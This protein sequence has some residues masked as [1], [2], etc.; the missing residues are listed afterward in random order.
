MHDVANL[1]GVASMTV[2][3]VINGTATVSEEARA[4]VLDAIV[5]LRYRPNDVARSLRQ[6]KSR[7]IGVIVPNIEDPF[8]AVCAQAV[9]RV[10]KGHGYSVSIAM[11]D[12]DPELEYTEAMLMLRRHVEG[13]VVIPAA[14]AVTHLDGSEL[15]GISMVTVDRPL[16][17]KKLDSVVVANRRGGTLAAQHL[18]DHGHRRITYM[19]LSSQLYTIKARFEGYRFAMTKAGLRLEAQYGNGSQSEMLETLRSLLSR[20]DAPSALFCSNN[21][22]TRNA[23][24]ALSELKIKV[25]ETVALVGFDDFETADLV[26]PGVTVVRQPATDLGRVGADLLFSRLKNDGPSL[27]V[28]QVTLPVELIVRGSCG[29]GHRMPSRS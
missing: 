11:S 4:R 21:L 25:P 23:L 10:A 6:Q 15:E 26:Q 14:G 28:R 13:I 19:G 5:K 22:T 27:A 24:H 8:F 18:I 9:S 7:Q 17:G 12:E 3:R 2:S 1:A 16:R 29:G 20:R